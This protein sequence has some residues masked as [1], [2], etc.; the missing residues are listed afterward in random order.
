MLI[1]TIQ[2]QIMITAPENI[3]KT[4]WKIQLM[5]YVYKKKGTEQLFSENILMSTTVL[6]F[7]L[8]GIN[9]LHSEE[10]G[11]IKKIPWN[12]QKIYF[13]NNNLKIFP[14]DISTTKLQNMSQKAFQQPG[15][16]RL[17]RDNR[18]IQKVICRR[19]VANPN[20]ISPMSLQIE[21]LNTSKNII[22]T[23]HHSWW[24]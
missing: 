8:A 6:M 10:I 22:K 20:T 13:R 24:F 2:W 1:I 12:C 18:S 9:G 14:A 15:R 7:L 11:N 16:L 21:L 3:G 19:L 4:R 23:K 17:P 5:G